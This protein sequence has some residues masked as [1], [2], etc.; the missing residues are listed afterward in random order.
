MPNEVNDDLLQQFVNGDE[1]AF[2]ALFRRFE[3]EVNAWILRIV[4][5]GSSAED[6]HV[7][8]F[9]RAYRARARFDWSRSFGASMRT[10]AT[11]AA[12]DHLNA[13]GPPVRVMTADYD[14]A[15]PAMGDDG[16]NRRCHLPSTS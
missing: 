13:Q 4:R 3:G 14:V 6:V 5:D 10:I 8:A 1:A 9:W 15:G 11:N 7:D 2:E 12:R 16:L